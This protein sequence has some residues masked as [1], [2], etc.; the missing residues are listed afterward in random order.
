MPFCRHRCDYCA[1]AT[2][3]DR[4]HLIAQYLA[5]CRRQVQAE[6]AAGVPPITSVFFGGGTPSH[7]PADALLDVLAA[8]PLA[9]GAEVTVECNPD[10]VSP[11]LL[12]QYE[13]GGVTRLS[14]GIQS[15]STMV[16]HELGRRH[17]PANVQR[18]A[19]AAHGVGLPF[20]VDLIYGAV[21]ETLDEWS[22]TLDAAIAL[23]PVHV[24]A[25]AL[26]VEP[27][28][29]LWRDRSRH[30]DD[31]HQ[32]AEYRLAT[33]RFEAAG[34]EWYELS[35]WALPGQKCRH[36]LLYWSGG[37]YLA[38]GCAAHGHRGGVRHWNVRTPERYIA[39]IDAGRSPV[40]GAERL[41]AD[42]ARVEALQLALR[43]RDGVPAAAFA[44]SDLAA[45]D[46]LLEPVDGGRD[47]RRVRLTVDGRLLANEVA[48]RVR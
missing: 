7:V 43:T 15:M 12:R 28:T 48:V 2:W 44:A 9:S 23:E 29:P 4:D 47:T 42:H 38:I 26:T 27:G 3:A 16:L 22:A 36:N 17:D 32:A 14:F 31:D 33:E 6:I 20:S 1:F 13:N 21:G 8:F 34:F 46:R 18:A 19:A 11:Q 5:A 37:E 41:D 35:N 10:D 25:Y 40:R 30:P 39:A 24:S 45:L